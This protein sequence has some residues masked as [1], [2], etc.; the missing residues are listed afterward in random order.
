MCREVGSEKARRTAKSGKKG[1]YNAAIE[2]LC[3]R[4]AMKTKRL[5]TLLIPVAAAIL[6]GCA[7]M[8][9]STTPPGVPGGRP[10]HVLGYLKPAHLADS[11]AFLPGPPAPGSA[12]F[13]A[14]EETYRKTR[15]L[16]DT[17]RWQQATK[18]AAL[19][20]P[21]AAG[22]FAC[23][24]GQPIS[25]EATPHLNALLS[26]LR[27]DTALTGASAKNHYRRQRPYLAHGDTSCTP[28][29]K[30]KADS[31][32]SSHAA[33]GWAWALMLA[34]LAPQRGDALLKRGLTFGDS[35]I[36]CGV[37]W[38]SDVE[39]GRLVGAATIS[40]LH[41]EPEF[42]T[43]LKFARQEIR[44]AASAEWLSSPACAAESSALKGAD[45]AP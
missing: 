43:Q 14:D 1:R 32:P 28:T 36:I 9:P 35:R 45:S 24:L 39:A 27:A 10:D 22:A 6:A 17:P 38:Q 23:A 8:A 31:Y 42:L 26:R 34:E 3:C 20:F 18:D 7:G 29:E 2:T 12:A 25:A 19:G 5:R 33:I 11:K 13:A 40:R 21:E 16:R 37:H 30:H 4:P 15:T 44:P 41:A